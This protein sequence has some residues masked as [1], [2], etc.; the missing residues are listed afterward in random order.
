MSATHPRIQAMTNSLA[1]GVVPQS[2]PTI[3]ET[4]QM[5]LLS[6][7]SSCD[8]VIAHNILTLHF[9]IP[10]AQAVATLAADSLRNRLISWT[11]DIAAVNPL[12]INELHAGHPWELFR[13][14]LPGVRYV[15]ISR[16]RSTELRSV[17]SSTTPH[18][19]RIE[20]PHPTVIPNGI[21]LLDTISFSTQL[22]TQVGVDSVARRSPVLLS[23]VRI[24][25]R[26]NL[27]LAVRVTAD[28]TLRGLDPVLLV[29]G[30]VWGHHPDRALAY[31]AELDRLT[32]ELNVESR[33]HFLAR[34]MNRSLHPSELSSLYQLADVV[35]LPSNSEGFGLPILEAG[36]HRVPLVASN[37]A[38]F[39]EIA[40]DNASFFE[41]DAF[42]NDVAD[43][44]VRAHESTRLRIRIVNEYAWDAIYDRDIDPLLSEVRDQS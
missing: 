20:C 9:N 22:R 24:T 38:V 15:T 4:L 7:V 2:F 14:P 6:A 36:L 13:Q 34:D 17:W 10:L 41:A 26:K 21:D 11:H 16:E 35:M 5:E 1:S 42:P 29:T 43:L 28:L 39:R 31:L 12:Y 44:V 23:P 18:G 3:T 32:R 37:L 30:P 27:E 25:R 8:V 40:G 19:V 33:V